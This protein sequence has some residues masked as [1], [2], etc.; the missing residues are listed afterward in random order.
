M[1]CQESLV[2]YTVSGKDSIVLEIEFFAI[3]HSLRI[4]SDS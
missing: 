3:A 4:Q 2:I 1:P